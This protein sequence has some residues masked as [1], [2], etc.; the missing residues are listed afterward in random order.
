MKTV[1]FY[2]SLI[3]PRCQM[4]GVSLSRLLAEFPDVTLEKVEYLTHLGRSREAGVQSIPTLVS[5]DRRL[6]GFYLTKK[7]IRQFLE[8]L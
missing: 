2:H 1:T 3:C 6:S 4:A 7:K 5:R 8:A